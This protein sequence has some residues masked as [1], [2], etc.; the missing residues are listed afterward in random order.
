MTYWA[1]IKDAWQPVT[2]ITHHWHNHP[3]TVILDNEQIWNVQPW[4]L[5]DSDSIPVEEP[6]APGSDVESL[7]ALWDNSRES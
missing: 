5:V 4:E 1:Y 7:R 6:Q 2:L 3:S